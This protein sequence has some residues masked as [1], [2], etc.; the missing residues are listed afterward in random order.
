MK[1]TWANQILEDISSQDVW[2]V[3][4]WTIGYHNYP[5]PIL[6]R[7]QGILPAITLEEKCDT[8]RDTLYQ[9]PLPLLVPVVT[10]LTQRVSNELSYTEITHMEVSEAL[11]FTNL[12]TA[13]GP[14]Q[15]TYTLIKWAWL[16]AAN[17]IIALFQRCLNIGYHPVQWR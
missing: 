15:I 6:T 3:H 7:G 8:L 2:S 17:L 14:S 5:M 9:E 1:R 10:N 13:P 4:K 11:F 16:I 12:N